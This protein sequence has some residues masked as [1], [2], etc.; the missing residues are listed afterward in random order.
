[1]HLY[2]WC[3]MLGSIHCHKVCEQ[4]VDTWSPGK[5]GPEMG[6]EWILEGHGKGL[7]WCWVNPEEGLWQYV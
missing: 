6:L 2:L 1:M 4:L 7:L 5:N 3:C